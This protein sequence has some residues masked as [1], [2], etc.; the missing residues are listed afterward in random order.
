MSSFS[1]L[2][3]LIACLLL[4]GLPVAAQTADPINLDDTATV[5]VPNGWERFDTADYAA[6]YDF[7][8]DFEGTVLAVDEV[9]VL[10]LTPAQVDE[11]LGADASDDPIERFAALQTTL[12]GYDLDTEEVESDTVF[13]YDALRWYYVVDDSEGEAYLLST[14]EDSAA[15]FFVDLLG[16]DDTL[17]DEPLTSQIDSIFESLTLIDS[18]TPDTPD[19]P[20]STAE[21]VPGI[22]VVLPAGWE[23]TPAGEY[24]SY[25]AEIPNLEATIL[26][27]EDIWIL[28][29][30]PDQVEALLDGADT[31]DATSLLIDV[32][33]LL[34]DEVIDTDQI[35]ETTIG[36]VD[37]A[38]WYY[39]Y[40]S[41]NEDEE[42]TEGEAYVFPDPETGASF[43]VD[44]Y[45]GEDTLKPNSDDLS[46]ILESI[47][48]LSAET[49]R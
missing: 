28:I 39:F 16:P 31:E 1:R 17:H 40:E 21:L 48:A 38:V 20:T 12:Y 18:D 22:E 44:I 46:A 24:D 5:V 7:V 30:T 14:D 19:S 32:Y 23:A 15:G 26:A 45:G 3:V 37:A 25:F 29:L 41:D 42:N 34:Y 35:E 2:L 4:A 49:S 47:A 10:I 36:G 8:T 43:F 11:V 9:A 33:N 6:F 13:G 27:N